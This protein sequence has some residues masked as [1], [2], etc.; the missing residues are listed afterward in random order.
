[1]FAGLA[2]ALSSETVVGNEEIL[3][4]ALLCVYSGVNKKRQLNNM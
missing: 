2:M 3:E 1:M 4:Y